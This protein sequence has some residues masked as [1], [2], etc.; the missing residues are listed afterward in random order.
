MKEG[1]TTQRLYPRVPRSSFQL[2]GLLLRLLY[3]CLGHHL[4]TPHYCTINGLLEILIGWL[5]NDNHERSTTIPRTTVSSIRRATIFNTTP[6]IVARWFVLFLVC[7]CLI[8]GFVFRSLLTLF[9]HFLLILSFLLTNR[10][11]AWPAR[12]ATRT[13][14]QRISGN[15]TTVSC[16][17]KASW[18]E[19]AKPCCAARCLP[20]PHTSAARA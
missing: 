18:N 14:I 8:T 10:V 6:Y 11:H 19:E 13:T 5:D 1:H 2:V 12:L 7:L 9:I 20:L 16:V 4:L 15:H 17:V 3:T